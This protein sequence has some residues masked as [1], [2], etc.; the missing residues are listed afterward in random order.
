[1]YLG[2]RLTSHC[3]KL[4][5][6]VSLG[7]RVAVVLRCHDLTI[8]SG[9][10]DGDEVATVGGIEVDGL[11]K[12]VGALAHGAYDIVGHLG[13]VGR[14]VLDAV[15]GAIEGRADELGHAAID[16]G[17]ALAGSLLDIEH[18]RDEAA[19]LGHDATTQLEVEGLPGIQAQV[20]AEHL[21]VGVEVGDVLV[22]GVTVVDTQAS[23]YVDA[24]DGVLAALEELGELVHTVAQGHEV[25]HVENL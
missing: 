6:Q 5:A 19:T 8:G 22:V 10:A 23:T 24:A 1:M 25:N 13:L 14:D 3:S 11:A 4:I 20:L 15:I 2:S 12:H 7:Q 18:A 9:R 16:D 17:E 21:E